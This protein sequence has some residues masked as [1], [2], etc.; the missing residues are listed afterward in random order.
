MCLFERTKKELKKKK[1]TS[2]AVKV[3]GKGDDHSDVPFFFFSIR[4]KACAIVGEGRAS[5]Y[6]KKKK[7]M[8]KRQ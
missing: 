3:G 6:E 7:S 5:K 1:K 2:N 8:E 4:C